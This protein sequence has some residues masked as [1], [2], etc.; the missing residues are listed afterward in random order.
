MQS[1]VRPTR[2]ADALAALADCNSSILAGGTD[3]YPARLDPRPSERV[4]D[5]TAIGALRGIRDR[6]EH[7]R[8]GATTTWA[9]V[10]EA[11]LPA[12]FDALKL[13]AKEVG[14]VQIQNTGTIAG[15]VCNAS[16]A[17]DGVPALLVMDAR[18]ELASVGGER[19]LPLQEFILGPRRTAL[20]PGELVTA[21]TV[22][23]PSGSARSSFLK[24]GARKYLLISI[25]MVAAA[26]E[27]D[28]NVVTAARVAVGACSPQAR[29]L[30]ALEDALKGRR[31]DALD[32][33]VRA[34]H[35][36]PLA[37]I[38]DVRADASYR[39]HAALELVRRGLRGLA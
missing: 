8:I 37:P 22:P 33:A 7:W 32:T 19:S 6:G 17:A 20:R 21:I 14:G 12:Y 2:L 3:F 28:G 1:Y 18:V 31:S 16:P 35:L 29:R 30:P 24:L 26:I 27:T 34:E 38:S 11:R 9:D 5:I 39:E 15:N 10:I 36:A 25:A 23:K 13:S 4:L